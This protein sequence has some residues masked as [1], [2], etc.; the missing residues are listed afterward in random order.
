MPARAVT[1][2]EEATRAVPRS[3]KAWAGLALAT[4][5]SGANGFRDA[6]IDA[7]TALGLDPSQAEAHYVRAIV[8]FYGSWD[9]DRA[10]DEFA[11]AIAANPA[12]AEAH[13]DL[14]AV[15]SAEGRHDE[16]IA[17]MQRAFELDPLSPEVVSDVGW[18]YYFARRYAEAASWCERTLALEPTFYWAHRCIVLARLRQH[19]TAGATAAAVADLRARDAPAA[20]IAEVDHDGLAP[21]WRWELAREAEHGDRADRAVTRLAGGDPSGALDELEHAVTS[22]RGWLLPFLSVDPTFDE[23][24]SEP[25]F[26][27]VRR[28]V[29]MR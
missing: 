26:A 20:T 29:T 11:A 15:Y 2:F 1:A 24:R 22:H 14:A 7:T 12:F 6:D 17:S 13:H 25:R 23:L 16:A 9:V 8:A 3:A 19:D 27:A 18:Y 4:L 10:H 5:R 21:Y 28:A